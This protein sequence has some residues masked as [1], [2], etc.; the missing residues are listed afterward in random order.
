MIITLTGATFSTSI[1]T[2]DS[3][4]IQTSITGGGLTASESNIKSI[5]KDDTAG[6]TLTYTYNT[7]NYKY[8]NGTVTDATGATV[9]SISGSNGTVTVTLN[10][11]NTIKGKITIAILMEYIGSGEDS[12]TYTFTINPT[13]TS[14]IVTLSA[15]GYSTVSG[16]G[17]Q[18]I[19]VANGTSVSWS[20]SKSGYVEQNG[21]WIANGANE[22]K[23]VTLTISGSTDPTP[24]D[25]PNL[26]QGYISGATVDNELNTRVRI[27]GLVSGAFSIECNDGYVI[28]A[29]QECTTTT[30]SASDAIIVTS[31]QLETSYS[32]GSTGKYYAITFCKTSAT[33][34]ISP[35]ESI[36]KSFS[37]TIVAITPGDSTTDDTVAGTD[38]NYTLVQGAHVQN[39]SSLY[40]GT[41]RVTT[42]KAIKG[43]F[44][45]TVNSGYAIRAVYE[46][47]KE[48]G[49]T[50]GTMV[51]ETS[52]TRTS[53][54]SNNDSKYYGVTFTLASPNS[55]NDIAPT[56]DIV[57][58]WKYV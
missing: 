57:A 22:T 10:A 50:K 13:P 1:G 4:F 21:T 56:E 12:S 54:T 24:G 36:V 14:A 42:P 20:V 27:D 7:E 15:T 17:S 9:G 8:T 6:A 48:S 31:D 11:G 34:S 40:Q 43:K 37:G 5:R 45:V 44:T 23:S 41:N 46:Y 25:L 55:A 2:L 29:I 38:V 53:F 58:S 26:V 16:T 47:T 3:W 30:P 18:N 35:S 52:E 39:D 19:T 49:D 33:T 51:A 28:R 32:G